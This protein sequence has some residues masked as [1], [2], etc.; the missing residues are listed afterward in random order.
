MNLSVVLPAHNE[1]ANL[2]PLLDEI[3]RCLQ[4]LGWDYEVIVVDDGSTDGTRQLLERYLSDRIKEVYNQTKSGYGGALRAGFAAATKE[5]IF[6]MDTD[7]QFDIAELSRLAEHS[8]D[9][10]LVIGYRAHRQDHFIRK[11]NA[12]IF[13]WSVRLLFNLWIK[14]IDCAFKLIRRDVIVRAKL[15]SRGA[16]INTELLVKAKNMGCR[17]RQVPV[18]HFPRLLGQPSGANIKVIL[19]AM[20]ELASFRLTG[21]VR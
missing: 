5:W 10:D 2:G 20:R 12:A 21:H 1:A 6:F 7:R 4:G 19:R 13:N 16:L 17:I 8:N 3:V 11:I 14:D 9:N 18:S 15:E